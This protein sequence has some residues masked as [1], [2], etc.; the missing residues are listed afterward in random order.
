M[1]LSI[2]TINRNNAVGLEKTMRSVAA[3]IDGDFEYVVIDGASTDGSVE[4]IRSF[5]SSLGER[6]KW[7]SE[8]DK[9]IYNAMNKGIAMATGDYLQFLNSGDSLVSNDITLRMTEALKNKEY[10]SILYGNMLKDMPGGKAMRDRCFA[11]REISFL[12]FYTGSLNHS[13]AYIRRS[14]F[15]R[16]GMYDEGFKIVSD[17]KWFLQAIIL[18]GEK[19]VYVDMDVTLFDM[20]G[21]SE[22]NKALDKTERRRVLNE[23]IPSTILADYDRWALSIN[24]M[25]RLERHPWAN[26][27]VTLLER[28]LFKMEKRRNRKRGEYEF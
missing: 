25:R 13:S 23:L 19:P 24:R 27:I 11:G 4:V 17:W 3:Q 2:I 14:L 10:P 21:I 22:K 9:G 18:G 6:L 15:N 12:G 5:E 1:I 7:I 20:N 26:R 16:Y 8:P 28:G